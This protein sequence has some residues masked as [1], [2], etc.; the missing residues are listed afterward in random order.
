MILGQRRPA[1]RRRFLQGKWRRLAAMANGHGFM[2]YKIAEQR[3]R[4][5]MVPILM[6]GGKPVDGQSLFATIFGT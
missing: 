2:S 3:L 5:A 6:A 4:L 1:V